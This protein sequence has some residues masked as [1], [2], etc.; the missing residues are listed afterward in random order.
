M[1]QVFISYSHQNTPKVK[2]IADGL[3]AAGYALWWDRKL[4]AA[5]DFTKN[6]EAE[7]DASQCVVVVWSATARNSL[8]VRAEASAALEQDK[9]VQVSADRS[10]PPLPFTM[11]HLLDLSDWRGDCTHET[12][13]DLAGSVNNVLAGGG[14]Q[15]REAAKRAAP[16][17]FAPLVAIGA[18]SIGL[19]AL[20]GGLAVAM[21][22][23]P[24]QADAFGSAT[25]GAFIVACLGLSYMLMR[26]VEIGL[27]SKRTA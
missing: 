3:S 8:W 23:A 2:L 19:V 9:L 7:L 10:K 18:G 16:S 27:A 22:N 11:L 20:T 4:H 21:A 5:D 25:L 6:I 12:W 13:R 24:Q 14:S 15:E 26:T 17:L 1:A